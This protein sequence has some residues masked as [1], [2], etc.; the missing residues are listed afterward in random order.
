M[1]LKVHGQFVEV[2][3]NK[4]LSSIPNA[5]TSP[6]MG[7][8]TNISFRNTSLNLV[9]QL[10]WVFYILGFLTWNFVGFNAMGSTSID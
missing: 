10:P 3:Q 8:I 7:S 5:Y 1:G 2:L 4:D 9:L 6:R